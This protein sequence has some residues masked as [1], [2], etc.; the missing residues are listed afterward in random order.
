MLESTDKDLTML[1]PG[2]HHKVK[3]KKT[4]F[5]H[6]VKNLLSKKVFKLTPGR[7]HEH[8]QKFERNLLAPLDVSSQ[9][10]WL[11]DLRKK[12]VKTYSK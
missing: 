6:L 3:S 12:L 1:M 7:E 4:D 5:D 11:N 10:V 9:I 8:F 2:G